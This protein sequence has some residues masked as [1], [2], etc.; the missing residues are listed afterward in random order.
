MKLAQPAPRHPLVKRMQLRNLI[1]RSIAK[2]ISLKA[3]W[4][5]LSPEVT[6]LMTHNCFMALL[7]ELGSYSCDWILELGRREVDVT[8][9]QIY[10]LAREAWRLR[11]PGEAR[12]WEK[13]FRRPD[14]RLL[15]TE[16]ERDHLASLPPTFTVFQV[17]APRGRLS[18]LRWTESHE[19]AILE[20]WRGHR[21]YLI[22]SVVIGEC[23]PE[24][25]LAVFK[26]S[27]FAEYVIPARRLRILEV[28][29]LTSYR[30]VDSGVEEDEPAA[31]EEPLPEEDR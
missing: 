8:Q 30:T 11:A 2:E 22:P 25:V 7:H 20:G 13:F 3:G 4:T 5:S 14:E 28:E 6:Q 17:K 21:Q 16:Q 27:E 18:S 15:M 23:N 29:K 9:E 12:I 31:A 10:S 1:R 24:D 26:F 19:A